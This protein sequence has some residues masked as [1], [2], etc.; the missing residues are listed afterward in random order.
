VAAPR[1]RVIPVVIIAIRSRP[2]L[3]AW[4]L[5]L[6]EGQTLGPSPWQFPG[7]LLPLVHEV[8]VG[9]ASRQPQPQR[10]RL[11]RPLPVR[12]GLLRGRCLRRPGGPGSPL[13]RPRATAG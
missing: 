3:R 9:A 6:L 5:E 13:Q 7:L 8:V 12:R 2:P 1:R 10:G 11:R 4:G